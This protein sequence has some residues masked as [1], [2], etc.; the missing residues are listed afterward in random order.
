MSRCRV[1]VMSK[2]IQKTSIDTSSGI[3]KP[4]LDARMR[5]NLA[6]AAHMDFFSN[7]T[8]GK[9]EEIFLC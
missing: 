9:D 7:C 1:E 3:D 2:P 5:E 4:R 8:R 6:H